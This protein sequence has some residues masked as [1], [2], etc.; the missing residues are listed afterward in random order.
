MT[1]LI[2]GAAG[3]VGK[4]LLKSCLTRF[5]LV[6]RSKVRAV[7]RRV[8]N[9]AVPDVKYVC[10]GNIN[11]QTKWNEILFGITTIV[12]LAA[13]VHIL[14][15]TSPEALET[16]RSVNVAGTLNLA[17]QA[18]ELGVKRFVFVSSVGV[19]GSQT[20]L[21][22]PFTEVDL[23]NPVNPY[24]L[25]KWEA[26]KG[27]L[28]IAYETGLEIVIIRPPLVYGYNAPG[29]FGYLT[30]MMKLGWPL[31]LD[32]VNNQRSFV[33]LENLLDFILTCVNHSQAVNHT[34][35]VSDG[36]DLST[37]DFVRGMAN[38][39]GV[40]V[41]M[42]PV[43]VFVLKAGGV[44]LGKVDVVDRLCGNLQVDI[45]KAR[46]LLGWTPPL[47]V[48]AGLLMAQMQRL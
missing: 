24:A 16:F 8:P 45:S 42:L 20:L 25:S 40:P 6:H 21:G 5:E 41:R 32:S 15:D 17:R 13:R 36:Q 38:A 31:P 7:V 9:D 18:F 10:V 14:K 23:P 35:L 29:N 39:A 27:L 43:P 30:R 1:L 22:K 47:T 3:F 34:F 44:L 28:Q 37:R 2:T 4:A 11:G 46:I 19:N 26:E 33:A 48:E 12:H